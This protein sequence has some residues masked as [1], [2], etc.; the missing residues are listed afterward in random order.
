MD[1]TGL[2]PGWFAWQTETPT[3]MLFPRPLDSCRI[4]LYIL[5][6][7]DVKLKCTGFSKTY[8]SHQFDKRFHKN[9]CSEEIPQ[10]LTIV[11]QE[12][13]DV[14]YS[15]QWLGLHMLYCVLL[16]NCRWQWWKPYYACLNKC[17][18]YVNIGKASSWQSETC[19][20]LI[21]HVNTFKY[22]VL[23]LYYWHLECR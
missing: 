14:L 20:P 12:K 15:S 18:L 3:I 19:T 10:C 16:F 17:T 1:R 6:S 7:G 23:W 11:R 9:K 5:K 13:R 22:G 2:K 21:N 8:I 4:I